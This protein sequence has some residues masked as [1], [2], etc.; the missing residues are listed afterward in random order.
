MYP[1][2]K[3]LLS[4]FNGHGVKYLIV[5]GHAVSFYG[6]PRAT[7]DIDL[8]VGAEMENARAI[9]TALASFG[10]P[11][12]EITMEDLANPNQFFRFGREPVAIDILP[13]IDGVEFASAWANRVEGLIDP[14]SGLRAYFISRA[15]LIQAKLAAG[16]L[17]DLA[18]VESIREAMKAETKVESAGSE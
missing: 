9:Y 16:R 12:Q 11:L 6:Q 18:D 17:G 1:D 4:A 14:A 2:F 13:S 10:A 3:A 8:F 7:K 15:D 5:G